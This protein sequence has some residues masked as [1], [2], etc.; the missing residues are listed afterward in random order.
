MDNTVSESANPEGSVWHRWD[1]HIHMPGTLNNDN[2][3]GEDAVEEYV[4]RLNAANPPIRAVGITDYYVLDSYEKLL[5]IKEKGDLPHLELLFPNIELRFAVNAPK[6]SPINVH[7]LVCPDNPDHIEQT[8]RFLRELKFQYKGESYGCTNDELIRL[9]RSFNPKAENDAHALKLGV[10]QSKI[11]PQDLRVAFKQ[12]KWATDNIMVAIAGSKTDGT[13]QLQDGGLKAIREELQRLSH[14]IFSGRPGDREYWCGN[15]PD[16]MEVL[17]NTY[18]GLKPCLHGCDAH[19]H[20]KVGNPD[21]ERYCWVRGDLTFE[22]LRQICFEPE[23]RVYIGKEPPSGARPSDTIKSISVKGADWMKTPEMQINSGLV[24]IIGA[25]GSGK[26]A[27]VEMISA[28]AKSVDYNHTKRSFLERAK[29][30]LHDTTSVLNWENGESTSSSVHMVDLEAENDD[31]RARYL[32]QQFVDQLC[33]S[34]GL[35]DDLILE[36]ERVIFEAH[37]SEKRLGARSFEE[38]REFKTQSVQ[39][40]MDKYREALS[41]IGDDLSV[42]SDLERSLEEL[43]RKRATEHAAI[44]RM[45]SDRKKLTPTNN[46]VLLERLEMVRTA[47]EQ[48]SHVIAKLEKKELNLDALKDEA[49]QFKDSESVVRLNQLK[50][51][52]SEAELTDEQWNIFALSYKGDVDT[53]LS[54]QL[55]TARENIV[56]HKGPANDEVL[57]IPDKSK[58]PPYFDDNVDMSK[59]PYS[60]LLKEQRRLEAHIGVDD[61][62]KRKYNDL[63][64]KIVRAEAALKQRDEEVKKAEAAPAK[65][66]ELLKQREETY[67][68]LISQIEKEAEVLRELYQP[69]QDRLDKQQGTLG[70]LAFSVKR[71]VDIDSWAEAGERLIDKSR[72]GRFKGVGTLTDIIKKELEDIWQKGTAKEIAEAMS[73]F[74]SEYRGDFW[75]HAFEDALKNRETKKNWSDQISAWL[76]GTDHVEVSYG[77]DY[78]STDIQRLSPGTRGIVLLLLYLTIDIDDE[79]PLIIDQP[80]ENLDPESVYLELVACF[81]EASH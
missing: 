44:E 4:K 61:D 70:K 52:Y 59:L 17:R 31:P 38:L 21:E 60:L 79:R 18:G 28:G 80:E 65:I 51:R 22:T 40:R 11:T 75:K 5:A 10:E 42:L 25:R 41:E 72:S 23:R 35:A 56:A 64:A 30:Y 7:L 77:L 33:S 73:R 47:A 55:K 58:A 14:I 71:K 29:D 27:L 76:Y 68:N 62:R 69:L 78:E 32:S 45:K 8:K 12:S 54:M 20:E 63:S 43:K 74:R 39:R 66:D 3:K 1:P 49:K 2:F 53:L 48:K 16:T 24:A 19:D 37:E 6:S 67:C 36:I 50:T 15:G 13:A 46:K 81:K 57:E 9:G 26:T 34:D